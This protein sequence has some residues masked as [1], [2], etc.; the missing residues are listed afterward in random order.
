MTASSAT[1]VHT[2]SREAT[3][4]VGIARVAAAGRVTAAR[5]AAAARAERER[6]DLHALLEVW[7]A[8]IKALGAIEVG[9]KI[10][11]SEG[12]KW[13]L[14]VPIDTAAWFL[15]RAILENDDVEANGRDASGEFVGTCL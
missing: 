3:A 2:S 15:T 14:F 13:R 10:T 1:L 9:C 5:Q 8:D 7:V 6:R 4:S 11:L 12:G